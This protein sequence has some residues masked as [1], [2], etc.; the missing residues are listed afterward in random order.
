VNAQSFP[1]DVLSIGLGGLSKT[2]GLPQVKLGWMA[3]AGP[4]ALLG[5]LRNRL[6]LACDTYL[7]VSTPVQLAAPD[8]LRRGA[9]VREQIHAR[10]RA[11]YRHLVTRAAGSSCVPLHADAGWYAVLQVPT[12]ET[13]EDLAVNLLTRNRV[14]LHPGYFFD[15]PRESYLIVSLLPAA[16]VF[17]E[18]IERVLRHFDCTGRGATE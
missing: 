17:Q 5:E 3:L 1:G 11:N 13:E 15:F 12:Y 16:P 9:T 8:L 14:L 18:G 4:S 7:S 2:I 6:E 10:V